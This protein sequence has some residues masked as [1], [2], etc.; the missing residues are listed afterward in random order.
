MLMITLQSN[1]L[2]F[3]E[4][5]KGRNQENEIKVNSISNQLHHLT[6]HHPVKLMEIELSISIHIIH[7]DHGLT[8][9]Y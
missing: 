5:D 2:D 8:I 3:P 7:T 4:E 1:K 6:T 9:S